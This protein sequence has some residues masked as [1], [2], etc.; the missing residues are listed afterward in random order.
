MTTAY[1]GIGSNL[2]PAANVQA[3]VAA[4]RAELGPL[5]CS[6]VYETEPVGF[7]GPVFYNLVVRVET[8]LSLAEL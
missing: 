4:L 7:E 1:I 5:T 3:G 8:G 6:P 2:D